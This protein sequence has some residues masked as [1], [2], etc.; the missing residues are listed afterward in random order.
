[1]HRYTSTRTVVDVNS[2]SII[3]NIS[4]VKHFSFSKLLRTV[5][6]SQLEVSKNII[7]REKLKDPKFLG[8]ITEEVFSSLYTDSSVN[9]RKHW[10]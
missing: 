3:E 4:V 1:M 8:Q 10:C 6:N 5:N 7:L 9:R 2:R